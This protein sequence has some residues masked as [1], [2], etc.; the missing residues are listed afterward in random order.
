M[1][2]PLWNSIVFGA[3]FLFAVARW[4][5]YATPQVARVQ[6]PSDGWNAP[7]RF[8]SNNFRRTV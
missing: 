3:L 4:A 8:D 7:G 5:R 2:A 1:Q 6:A